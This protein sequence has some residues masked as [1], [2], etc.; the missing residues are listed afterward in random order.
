MI[1]GMAFQQAMIVGLVLKTSYDCRYDLSAGHVCRAAF[2]ATCDI[3]FRGPVNIHNHS[4]FL[5]KYFRV[6]TV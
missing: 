6:V 5:L 3:S 2:K 4:V 1:V